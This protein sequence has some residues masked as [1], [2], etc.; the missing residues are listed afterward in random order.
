LTIGTQTWGK[1][2]LNVG[3]RINGA[4][5]QT[6]N[7]GTNVIEKYCF[8]DLESNCT[9]NANGGLYQWDE[10]MNYVTTEGAQGICPANSHIPTDN[11]WKILEKQLGMS[12]AQADVAGY[13]GTDQGTQLKPGGLSGL[14]VPLAGYRFTNGT[15]DESLSGANLWSSSAGAS[16]WKRYLY[17][18]VATVSRYTSTKTYGF[19]IRCIGN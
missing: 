18:G 15:F 7:G 4:V 2:N 11:D 9:A 1:A 6:N 8:N 14:N 17:S 3:T 12:Q 5:S 19:S 10:A 16:A 13:R